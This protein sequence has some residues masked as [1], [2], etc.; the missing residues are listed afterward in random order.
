[1][2]VPAEVANDMAAHARYWVKRDRHIARA[3]ED[4]A[5]LIRDLLAG[6][7]V[8]HRRY[9]GLTGRLQRFTTRRQHHKG[10]PDFDRAVRTLREL[11]TER[12]R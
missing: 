1:M 7:Y 6:E 9:F 8:D 4:A 11:W 5:R 10:A 12:K 3:C 2:A